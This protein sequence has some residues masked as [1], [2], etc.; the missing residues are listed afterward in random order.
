MGKQIVKGIRAGLDNYR[1]RDP[2]EKRRNNVKEKYLTIQAPGEA[3]YRKKA[4]VQKHVQ[5]NNAKSIVQIIVQWR[6]GG[7]II[8]NV[9]IMAQWDSPGFILPMY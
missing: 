3:S 8:A 5:W 7:N 6:G 2:E 9:Q 1:G 4:K